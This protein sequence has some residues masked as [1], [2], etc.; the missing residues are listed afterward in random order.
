VKVEWV[1]L[2]RLLLLYTQM[3]PNYFLESGIFF[4][5][6]Q[7]LGSLNVHGESVAKLWS[8]FSPNLARLGMSPLLAITSCLVPSLVRKQSP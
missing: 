3:A 7:K 8:L 1:I 5:F 4:G 2:S 6:F